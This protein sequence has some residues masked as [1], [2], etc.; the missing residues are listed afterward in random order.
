MKS[1]GVRPLSVV[2]RT[3]IVS[4]V[5]SHGFVDHHHTLPVLTV[6][7]NQI[8]TAGGKNFQ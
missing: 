5:T 6:N 8:M 1:P 7:L 2:C 3:E 4:E